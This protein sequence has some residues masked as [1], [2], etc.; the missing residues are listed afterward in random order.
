MWSGGEARKAFELFAGGG[1]KHHNAYFKGDANSLMLA[2]DENAKS[3]PD[4]IFTIFQSIAEDDKVAI[5]SHIK[6]NP[7]ERGAVVMHI[8]QF[9][10]E[11]IIEMWDFG[12]Q[13]PEQIINE[14]GMF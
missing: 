7:A 10:N 6:Q 14:N 13:I 12:M 2:M 11:K 3:N 4:K 9:E 8:F 1:F 5:H